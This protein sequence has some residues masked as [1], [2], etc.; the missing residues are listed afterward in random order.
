[1]REGVIKQL[2][3]IHTE[4]PGI[5]PDQGDVGTTVTPQEGFVYVVVLHT[6]SGFRAKQVTKDQKQA[7][8]W[9]N[10]ELVIALYRELVIALFRCCISYDTAQEAI[11]YCGVIGPYQ[12]HTID[13]RNFPLYT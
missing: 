6:I 11:R 5:N 13:A 1:M 3:K 8:L 10:K 4:F 9:S 2:T 12:L 7:L